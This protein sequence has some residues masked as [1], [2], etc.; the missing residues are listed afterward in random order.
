MNYGGVVGAL[1]S[2]FVLQCGSIDQPDG[3]QPHGAGRAIS[4]ELEPVNCEIQFGDQRH[5]RALD[6][7]KR[8]NVLSIRSSSCFINKINA[9][10]A[11]SIAS[12]NACIKW[13]TSGRIV[14]FSKPE[15]THFRFE[16]TA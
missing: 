5:F 13:V 12:F 16:V 9:E 3:T 11:Y 2:S 14:S 15:V 4:L 8:W 6:V 10:C 7:R 1:L